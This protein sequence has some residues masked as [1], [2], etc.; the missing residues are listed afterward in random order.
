MLLLLL[1]GLSCRVERYGTYASLSLVL[2]TPPFHSRSLRSHRFGEGFY[3][4]CLHRRPNEEPRISIEPQQCGSARPQGLSM[5]L[6]QLQHSGENVT[7]LKFPIA[8]PIA[9][10]LF[11]SV[12]R[13]TQGAAIAGL[14]A[15]LLLVANSS[16]LLFAQSFSSGLRKQ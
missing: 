12:R 14:V 9:M 16:G 1:A 13:S 3:R 4:C 6:V 11:R 7:Q 10:L 15:A 5:R 2:Q 8:L